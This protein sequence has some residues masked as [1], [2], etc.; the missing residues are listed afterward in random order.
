MAAAGATFVINFVANAVL[1]RLLGP[2]EFGRY[3]YFVALATL[4]G[5]L[6][7]WW[8]LRYIHQV[9]LPA[10]PDDASRALGATFRNVA[11]AGLATAALGLAPPIVVQKT[12]G[13]LGE[14]SQPLHPAHLVMLG[15]AVFATGLVANL[16]SVFVGLSMFPPY[17]RLCVLVAVLS[18][19]VAVLL[20]I[21][22]QAVADLAVWGWVLANGLA[23]VLMYF[24][25][26]LPAPAIT[27]KYPVHGIG[28]RAFLF[29]TLSRVDGRLGVYLLSAVSVDEQVGLFVLSAGLGAMVL[30]ASSLASFISVPGL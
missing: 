9:H 25:A 13:L 20:R 2:A 24:L 11:L 7:D 8:G 16:T 6:T 4:L 30:R 10:H 5:S 21:E 22:R 18:L 1:A 15:G 29:N 14:G 28:V 12:F 19:A 26:R 27:S 17:N 3:G 23:A